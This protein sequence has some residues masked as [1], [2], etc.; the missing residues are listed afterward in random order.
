MPHTILAL[1]TELGEFSNE[2]ECFKHWKKN[3]RNDR[4]KRLD[5]FADCVHFTLSILNKM[6]EEVNEHNEGK[7]EDLVK[8]YVREDM[9]FETF[10][11]MSTEE[12]KKE[13][14][15]STEELI[16]CG[17]TSLFLE[18]YDL[19]CDLEMVAFLALLTNIMFILG[20][21]SEELVEAYVTKNKVNYERQANNY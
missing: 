21:T 19:L 7:E 17:L 9:T 8:P 15:N 20:Y 4:D 2:I 3:K 1:F 6:E 10:R 18:A 12:I 5:E 13:N 14:E 16:N 11:Q